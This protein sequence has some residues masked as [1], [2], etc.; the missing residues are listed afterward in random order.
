MTH[1]YTTS[2]DQCYFKNLNSITVYLRL[3][4]ICKPIEKFKQL[5]SLYF[6]SIISLKFSQIFICTV[7]TSQ[8]FTN[9]L[10]L[11]QIFFFKCL[12]LNLTSF[13]Y[14]FLNIF[15]LCLL[16]DHYTRICPHFYIKCSK[17]LPL[18]V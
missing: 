18:K 5:G 14:T 12:C 3:A 11:F 4:K 10:L 6:S 1:K 15:S 8:I 2:I 9:F 7:Y 17:L 13:S 16:I